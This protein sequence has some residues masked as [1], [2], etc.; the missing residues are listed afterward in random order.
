MHITEYLELKNGYLW[1]VVQFIHIDL[2]CVANVGSK[3]I[4]GMGAF[5]K[6]K[7]L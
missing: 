3:Y 2:R 5:F 4:Y 1:I 6:G 7:Q